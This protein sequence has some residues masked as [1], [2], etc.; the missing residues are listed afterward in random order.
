MCVLSTGL[1]AAYSCPWHVCAERRNT[2]TT[3]R[4]WMWTAPRR[5]QTDVC[6][7][8][9]VLVEETGELPS[10]T[11]VNKRE[12]KT[13]SHHDIIKEIVRLDGGT[14]DFAKCFIL[15]FLMIFCPLVYKP[16]FETKIPHFHAHTRSNTTTYNKLILRCMKL[17]QNKTKV[18]IVS[19]L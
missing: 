14:V 16:N 7:M 1:H 2:K 4:H 6:R 17:Y 8:T 9:T 19:R 13:N 12:K 18:L 15:L 5:L 11:L 3:G 10:T